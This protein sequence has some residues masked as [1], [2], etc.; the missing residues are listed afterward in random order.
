[1]TSNDS[2]AENWQR[3]KKSVGKKRVEA[4]IISEKIEYYLH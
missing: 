3:D 1:M 4:F 2:I